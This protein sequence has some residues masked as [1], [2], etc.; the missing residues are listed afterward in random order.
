MEYKIAQISTPQSSITYLIFIKALGDRKCIYYI[1]LIDEKK[2]T[3]HSGQL[4]FT[5]NLPCARRHTEAAPC[6][7]L[8]HLVNNPQ[9]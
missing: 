1:H 8:P 3:D 7:N 6:F 2:K 4:L 9:R 5:K